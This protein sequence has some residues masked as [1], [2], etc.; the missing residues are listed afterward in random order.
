MKDSF[1]MLQKMQTIGST[2]AIASLAAMC[3]LPRSLQM[4]IT[5]S[6]RHGDFA[7]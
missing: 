4:K 5:D 3:L 1:V 7:I 6:K 2:A